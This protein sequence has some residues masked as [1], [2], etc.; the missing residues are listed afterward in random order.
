MHTIET[1]SKSRRRFLGT[2]SA[3]MTGA[4]ALGVSDAKAMKTQ[5]R[6]VVH[7][8]EADSVIRSTPRNLPYSPPVLFR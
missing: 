7:D 4:M 3:L 1:V 2:V 8:I 5:I 6:H